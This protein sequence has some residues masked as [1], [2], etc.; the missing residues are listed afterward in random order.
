M[1]SAMIVIYGL[2]GVATM[3]FTMLSMIDDYDFPVPRSVIAG[4]ILGLI[5][6]LVWLVIGV[7]TAIQFTRKAW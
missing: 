6:P 7:R 3:V 5:W 2:L 1:I 4:F